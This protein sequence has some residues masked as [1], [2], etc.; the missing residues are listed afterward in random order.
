MQDKWRTF[1]KLHAATN[2]FRWRVRDAQRVLH[3]WLE[4]AQRPYVSW[5]GGKD[6]T[7]LLILLADMGRT[8][9]PLFTQCD[10]LDWPEKRAHCA[11]VA[12]QLGFLEHEIRESEVSAAEQFAKAGPGDAI[13][14]TFS[15]VIEKYER[16]VNPDGVALGIRAEESKDRR[17]MSLRGKLW[18]DARGMWR[19][20]PILHWSG[21]DVFAL[22]VSKNVSYMPLYDGV[23]RPPH[24]WRMSWPATP[25]YWTSG[26]AAELRRN[27]PQHFAR[28]AAMNPRLRNY[29]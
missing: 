3:R 14:G 12:R 28:L 21:E 24:E 4:H 22:I 2:E 17:R 1:Y 6:S 29:A 11:D 5:S 25:A 19:C 9:I 20:M 7:C 23:E 18:Q 15:H 26:G 13:V 16:D 10:D 27:F 8:D